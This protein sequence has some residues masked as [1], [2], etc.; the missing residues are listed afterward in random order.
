MICWSD[1]PSVCRAMLNR[2]QGDPHRRFVVI[3]Y[4]DGRG[5]QLFEGSETEAIEQAFQDPKAGILMNIEAWQ[6]QC[7]VSMPVWS[8]FGGQ[9]YGS[10]EKNIQ[11]G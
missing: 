7:I 3:E 2:A 8:L 11:T 9:M 6:L 5:Y 4:A 1:F 10:N